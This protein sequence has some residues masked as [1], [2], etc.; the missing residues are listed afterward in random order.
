MKIDF[1]W[2]PGKARLNIKKHGVY[3]EEA[4]TVFYDPDFCEEV[5]EDHSD[6]LETRYSMIGYSNEDNLLFVVFSEIESKD[7]KEIR[8]ISARQ[9]NRNERKQYE[10]ELC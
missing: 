2:D 3:F 10:E 1:S 7:G 8:I 4:V 5:D 9:A 6:Y